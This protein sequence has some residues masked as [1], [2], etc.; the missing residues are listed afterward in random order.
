MELPNDFCR[1][2]NGLPV[3]S[4]NISCPLQGYSIPKTE[5]KTN[6]NAIYTIIM[7]FTNKIDCKN[8]ISTMHLSALYLFT[9]IRIDE[10]ARY[11]TQKTKK[12][13]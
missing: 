11:K 8:R 6:P 10:S 4:G 7:Y 2:I 12:S 9:N 13:P 3:Y 1:K 5:D